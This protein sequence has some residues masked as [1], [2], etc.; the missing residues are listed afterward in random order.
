ME[1]FKRRKKLEFMTSEITSASLSSTIEQTLVWQS[2][3]QSDLYHCPC[4]KAVIQ[5]YTSYNQRW[6]YTARICY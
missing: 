5:T 4:T 6:L 1:K 3:D 2:P